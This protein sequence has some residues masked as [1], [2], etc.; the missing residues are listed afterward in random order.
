MA[1]TR[2]HVKKGDTVM[3]ISGKH[4]GKKGK[5][6]TCY[7]D[8][9]RVLIEGVNL[10]KKHTRPTAKAP[11]GGIKEQEAPVHSSIV[12]LVCPSCKEPARVG[13]KVLPGGER[14]RQCKRCGE[15]VD[16]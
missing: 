10:V 12:M 3:V 7:P 4:K 14:E 9:N 2:L 6:L 1:R 5:I 15:T 13:K 8:H 16:R 11:H